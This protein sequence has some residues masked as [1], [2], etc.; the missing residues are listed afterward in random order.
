VLPTDVAKVSPLARRS[1]HKSAARQ[2]LIEIVPPMTQT[3]HT[4]SAP[5]MVLESLDPGNAYMCGVNALSKRQLHG[6]CEHRLQ[7]GFSAA[8]INKRSNCDAGHNAGPDGPT[9]WVYVEPCAGPNRSLLDWEMSSERLIPNYFR[10]E[11][12]SP[13]L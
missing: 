5:H 12:D 8:G 1:S 4:W 3:P 9:Q 13:P 11:V 10:C 7:G 6:I 2:F